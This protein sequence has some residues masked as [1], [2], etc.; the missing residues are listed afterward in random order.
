MTPV[1]AA[2]AAWAAS[3]AL[4]VVA[5]QLTKQQNVVHHLLL[6]DRLDANKLQGLVRQWLGDADVG[7]LALHLDRLWH[8]DV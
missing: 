7:V 5:R 1:A 3:T 8:S 4:L 2:A 6:R